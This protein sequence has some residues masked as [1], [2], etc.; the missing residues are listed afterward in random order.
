MAEETKEIRISANQQKVSELLSK[1]GKSH[2]ELKGKGY[3][4]AQTG[5][6]GILIYSEENTNE[7]IDIFVMGEPSSFPSL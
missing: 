4:N 1:F 7:L 5:S 3:Y 2:T 6:Y